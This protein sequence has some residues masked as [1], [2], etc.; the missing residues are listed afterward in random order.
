MLPSISAIAT[1]GSTTI[2]I[3]TKGRALE[4]AISNSERTSD[5]Q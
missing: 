4:K 5:L 3:A 2:S 1:R